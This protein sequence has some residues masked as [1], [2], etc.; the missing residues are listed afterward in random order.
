LPNRLAPQTAATRRICE[1]DGLAADFYC[2]YFMGQ[3]NSG[4]EISPT[5]LAGIAALGAVLRLDIYTEMVNLEL[6]HW[7]KLPKPQW[8]GARRKGPR[9]SPAAT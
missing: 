6:E 4:F 7:L 1:E 9:L 8:C 5:T 3:A 2:G